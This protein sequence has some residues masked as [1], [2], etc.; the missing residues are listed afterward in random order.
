MER[1]WNTLHVNCQHCYWHG[2]YSK[3][4]CQSSTLLSKPCCHRSEGARVFVR[5]GKEDGVTEKAHY[6]AFPGD[7]TSASF[8]VKWTAYCVQVH[9][10]TIIDSVFILLIGGG[11]TWPHHTLHRWQLYGESNVLLVQQFWDFPY[12]YLATTWRLPSNPCDH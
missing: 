4:V 8:A 11:Q 1:Q 7:K 6:W 5:E 9:E 2:E 3:V 12:M 10:L